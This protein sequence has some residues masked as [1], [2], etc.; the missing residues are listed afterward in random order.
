MKVPPP[1]QV[2]APYVSDFMVI[3]LSVL[4]VPETGVDRYQGSCTPIEECIDMGAME[5][6]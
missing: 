4:K 5:R 1:S 2:S 6:E 3:P